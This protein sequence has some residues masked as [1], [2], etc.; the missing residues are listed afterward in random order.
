MNEETKTGLFAGV[1]VLLLVAA[2]LSQ[3]SA[4]VQN[5]DGAGELLFEKF[6]DVSRVAKIE[7]VVF[8]SD[9]GKH[10]RIE[11]ERSQD[12][13]WRITSKDGYP[14]DLDSQ[15]RNATTLLFDLKKL[16]VET[17]ERKQHEDFGVVEPKED[18][19]KSGDEG[20]GRLV[21][22]LD[23]DGEEIAAL[24]IGNKVEKEQD[25]MTA[26]AEPGE[27]FY[28]RVPG[29]DS[30]VST[31]IE[32]DSAIT[33]DFTDW[34]ETSLLNRSGFSYSAPSLKQVG[35][36]GLLPRGTDGFPTNSFYFTQDADAT[37]KWVGKG[38][39]F[40]NYEEIDFSTVDMI[41]G[42]FG[43]VK[44]LDAVKGPPEL[45]KLKVDQLATNELVP[46][47]LPEELLKNESIESVETFLGVMGDNGFLG[48]LGRRL[49]WLNG[50]TVLSMNDGVEVVLHFGERSR[51]D[52]ESGFPAGKYLTARA[53]F[54]K[55]LLKEPEAP[56]VEGNGTK[57]GSNLDKLKRA[58]AQNNPE[59]QEAVEEY[60]KK[61]AAGERQA[62]AL[63]GH[64]K[65]WLFIVSD[66][67][68]NKMRLLETNEPLRD[69]FVKNRTITASQILVGH[70][71]ANSEIKRTKAEAIARAGEALVMAKAA[72]A[73]FTALV[74][75]YS[76][77]NATK[78]KGG[79]I[80][81]FDYPRIARSHGP[82][83]ATAAFD[84]EI[85]ATS[86]VLEGNQ[87]FYILRRTK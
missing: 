17:Q 8:N 84:L 45:A 1:A 42:V 71:E 9:S 35:L 38:F 34:I 25:S 53:H 74:T 41:V 29:N 15:L 48:Q 36:A 30:V 51:A 21:K 37:P 81:S 24:I 40:D 2:I 57:P 19:V 79:D 70:M 67:D 75:E 55:T 12:G 52:E 22:Y 32:H 16:R 86:P 27:I 59:Y 77:D 20:V 5:T 83:L 11:V 68:Y 31:R 23:E 61:V 66:S 4:P 54:N 49:F 64:L 3:P 65:G 58:A 62:V 85:N 26:A 39:A 14:A 82:G 46:S 87:G 7:M 18:E 80:G 33:T 78:A 47:A 43:N 56:A 28:A 44:I 72:D 76:D 73:N 50:R 69:Q 6:E 60:E 13:A 10:S 63:D